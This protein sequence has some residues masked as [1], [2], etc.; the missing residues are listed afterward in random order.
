MPN[1]MIRKILFERDWRT[2]STRV[3]LIG[4]VGRISFEIVSRLP[5]KERRAVAVAFFRHIRPFLDRYSRGDVHHSDGSNDFRRNEERGFTLFPSAEFDTKLGRLGFNIRM[6]RLKRRR[7]QGQLAL[8]AKIS[9]KQL[10]LIERGLCCP[11]KA[12]LQRLERALDQ[13][14]P[15]RGVRKKVAN[16]TSAQRV[17]FSYV[18]D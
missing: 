2:P 5:P 9:R 4:F 11:H 16:V 13:P 10:S 12:T 6:A 3:T 7:S 1:A 14:V 17:K 18:Q 15:S 8:E